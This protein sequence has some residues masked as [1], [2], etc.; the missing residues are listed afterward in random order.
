[1][2]S[3]EFEENLNPEVIKQ[4]IAQKVG[5]VFEREQ[6]FNGKKYGALDLQASALTEWKDRPVI[7]ETKE[8]LIVKGDVRIILIENEGKGTSIQLHIA[9]EG[10]QPRVRQVYILNLPKEKKP[11]LITYIDKPVGPVGDVPAPMLPFNM[12][13]TEA[14]AKTLQ[15]FSKFLEQGKTILAEEKSSESV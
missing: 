2:E 3:T 15:A 10:E 11:E 14:S 7:D 8:P 6:S 12:E 1:M 13:T 5:K 9:P 4:E